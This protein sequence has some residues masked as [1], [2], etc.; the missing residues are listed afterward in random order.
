ML[1]NTGDLNSGLQVSS[2]ALIFFN[3]Y[4]CHAVPVEVWGCLSG[5]GSPLLPC[6]F[7]GQHS[8]HPAFTH[9]A[10]S[11]ALVFTFWLLKQWLKRY[12]HYVP[13]QKYFL[14]LYPYLILFPF[15]IV[16][17]LV[18]YLSLLAKSKDTERINNSSQI[19]GSFGWGWRE[20]GSGFRVELGRRNGFWSSVL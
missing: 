20:A 12:T 18:V 3:Q 11:P 14:S 13:P 16:L 6:E 8:D 2:P 19:S 4:A 10:I 17:V 1:S 9:W 7:Q 5:V 15:K